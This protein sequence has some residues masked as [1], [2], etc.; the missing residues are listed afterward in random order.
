VN[1]V[2]VNDLDLHVYDSA[3]TRYF[4][5]T[6]DPAN[7]SVA[8][9]RIQEDHLNNIEQVVIDNPPPGAYR[10]EIH[11]FN[12]PSGPQ[13]FSITVSPELV[14]CASAGFVALDSSKYPCGAT[15]TLTVIDC[16]LNTD[17]L[18]VESV[19]VTVT[20]DSEPAGEI[21]TLT[22]TAPE[23]AKFIAA[24]PLALS[25]A[26]GTLLIADG[27]AV[28]ATYV[29]ADDGQ[30][31]LNV[32][33]NANA[34]VDCQPPVIFNVQVINLGP[35][36]AT[37]TFDADEP[38]SATIRYGASCATLDS[39]VA[40]IGFQASRSIHVTGLT[41]DTSYFFAIDASDEAGNAMTDD[42]GG[43]CFGFATPQ[44]PDFFTEQFAADNDLSGWQLI[45]TPAATVDQYA[46]CAET[47]TG[48]LPIDP[49]GGTTLP[50]SDDGS[51][52]VTLGSGAQVQLYGTAYS[53]FYVN[54]NGN[55]TFNSADGTFS[56]SLGQHFGQP[57]VSGLFDDLNP[58]TGG[59][60]S[61]MQLVDRVVVTW[62]N[63]PEFST[64][65]QNTFQI[66]LHFDGE[67]RVN[68]A[69]LAATDGVVG[70]SAGNGQDPDFFETDLSAQGPC[71]PR[72]PTADDAAAET[73]RNT[74]VLINLT[75][76]DD[77]LPVPDHRFSAGARCAERS[78][79]RADHR[80]AVHARRRRCAGR[81]RAESGLRRFR[82][83]HVQGQRRR[84]APGRR[85]FERGH[86]LDR[87]RA[88]VADRAA[89]LPARL[90]PGLDGRESVGLGQ[91]L[92]PRQP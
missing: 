70:L 18:V 76:S 64:S 49:T 34:T 35:R 67:I 27:D 11:G 48:G 63:V 30:G 15:A 31:G 44:I 10:I 3:D 1:P 21:V 83:L 39:S 88:V 13:P 73:V 66:E 58:A 24:L 47:L 8:A 54:A 16:D 71:G 61:W 20:S 77:G 91:A 62:E 80:R 55:I 84:H 26:V 90:E 50:L 57:R 89:R 37:I 5:W 56:E 19:N 12:V 45:W 72:P 40:A 9:V 29:D 43:S 28:T 81:V 2:L 42:N 79:R 36:D 74:P 69:A 86:G 82:W 23:T 17:S 4:P 6:L 38:V 22:E 53:S 7:P 41:D 92:G 85:R 52:Q 32:V 68:Y 25:D 75:A 14:A 59:I 46:G 51:A 60:V 87:R 33:V 65:N 78:G